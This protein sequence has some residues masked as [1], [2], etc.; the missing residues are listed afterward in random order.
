M[1][2]KSEIQDILRF[3]TQDAKLSLQIALPKVK[4]LQK[5]NLVRYD[6]YSMTWLH[7]RHRALMKVI[8]IVKLADADFKTIE[9]IFHD[10]KTA[11]QIV[12][13]AKR[14]SKKRKSSGPSSASPSKRGRKIPEGENLTP[15]ATEQ[16]LALPNVDANLEDLMQISL[17]TNR[18][19]LVLAFAV[20]LLKYTMPSQPLSSRL[21]LAQAVV[22]ANSRSKAVSIGLETGSSAAEDGWGLGQPKVKIMT[23]EIHTLKRWGYNADEGTDAL[24]QVPNAQQALAKEEPVSESDHAV[25]SQN[26]IIG[27]VEKEP[28]LW[29]LDLESM[30][31][32]NKSLQRESSTGGLPIYTA[33]S[34]RAYLAK[35]F[36][37][38][39]TITEG[40]G[41]SK[42]KS[43]TPAERER[44][45][46]LLL[47][48][49]DLL[50]S[51]WAPFISIEDLDRRSWSWYVQVRPEVESGVA[52]W[53]SKGAVNLSDI[54]D[55][56][57]KG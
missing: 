42:K 53:G 25:L 26:T 39:A 7:F 33:Q 29:G 46:A 11:K 3:L 13:A 49:L 6:I 27:D 2:T 57:R 51:S 19:P 18:A 47:S 32:S 35:S 36:G 52:G 38:K 56:R 54:L 34:A 40:E 41:K 8:S 22:S 15:A 28:A 23:R 4:E 31:S 12:S 14:V 44:N 21:S 48:S 5:A 55:L 16:S 45:L 20:T 50:Y 10:E 30:R 17:H 37:S 1:T 43:I 24:D 9:N